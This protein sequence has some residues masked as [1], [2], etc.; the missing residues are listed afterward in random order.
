MTPR[1]GYSINKVVE[2]L[3]SDHIRGLSKEMRRAS[4]LMALDAAGV[5]IEEVLRDAGATRSNRFVRG[6]AEETV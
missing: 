6:R 2:M 5:S 4:V 1:R 3:Y